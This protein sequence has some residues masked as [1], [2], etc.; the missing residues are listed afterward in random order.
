MVMTAMRSSTVKVAVMA[1]CSIAIVIVVFVG[2]LYLG[3]RRAI[4]YLNVQMDGTQAMLAF[5]RISS[6]RRLQHLLSN[7]CANVASAQLK[8]DEDQDMQLLAGFVRGPLPSW[9]IK[10][11]EQGDPHLMAELQKVTVKPN[12]TWTIP[13]CRK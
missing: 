12:N 8:V 1:V 6:E 5:N 7:G 2:G 11:I 13:D 3:G 10:Y 4:A 9:T